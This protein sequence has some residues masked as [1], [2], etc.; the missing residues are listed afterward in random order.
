MFVQYSA[1]AYGAKYSDL[2]EAESTFIYP[3]E[4]LT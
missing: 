4:Q 3:E 2:P 1:P